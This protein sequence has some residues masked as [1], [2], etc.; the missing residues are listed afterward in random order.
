MGE[1]QIWVDEGMRLGHG[2]TSAGEA[3]VTGD[4]ACCNLS[5][6]IAA[7]SVRAAMVSS[8][9]LANGTSGCGFCKASVMSLAAISNRS[10]DDNCG[11]RI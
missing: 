1:F 2:T 9:T 7:K 5:L 8:P 10:V 4:G 6:K 3:Q 11:E